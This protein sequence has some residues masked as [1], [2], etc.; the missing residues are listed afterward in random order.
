MHWEWHIASVVLS[1]KSIQKSND[2]KTLEKPKLRDRLQIQAAG[3]CRSV[4]VMKDK[5]RLRS[6]QRP[7]ETEG[8]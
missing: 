2:E 8:M 5:A 1:P 7:E 3:L 4:K 6:C